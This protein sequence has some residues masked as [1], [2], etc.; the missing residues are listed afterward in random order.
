VVPSPAASSFESFPL[1]LPLPLIHAQGP[2]L[3]AVLN[4]GLGHAT[5]CEQLIAACI[6]E[7]K[8]VVLA[9]DGLALKYLRHRFP[10]LP[11]YEL[12]P[13]VIQY[14]QKHKVFQQFLLAFRF[15]KSVSIDFEAFKLIVQKIQPGIIVSDNRYGCYAPGFI[16]FIIT[17]QIQPQAPWYFRK[18][19]HWVVGHWLNKF[20]GIWV[21]DHEGPKNLSGK[22]SEPKR[23]QKVLYLGNTSRFYQVPLRPRKETGHVL[24][25]LS[26][27]EPHRSQLE[28]KIVEQ[29]E[30]I[31]YQVIIVRG[32]TQPLAKPFSENIIR[33]IDI[34]DT[35]TMTTLLSNAQLYIGR[36][37]YSTLMDLDALELSALLIPTPGQ[38]EQEYLARYH[39]H[40]PLWHFIHENELN[41]KVQLPGLLKKHPDL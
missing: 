5:R 24:C 20:D 28:Q 36:C 12:P 7:G 41:L 18:P 10:Q 13:L 22:L 26:G 4:W 38:P 35:S 39:A 37:G 16:N 32:T 8:E 2:V 21:P 15:Y 11:A 3:F 17:H 14:P 25:V 6:R 23:K 31:P 40:R 9:S 29:L 19:L 30:D 33:W 27:P 34:A 1:T